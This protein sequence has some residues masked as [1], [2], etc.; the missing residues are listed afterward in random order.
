MPAFDRDSAS[1]RII[2]S[3]GATPNP[4]R[5]LMLLYMACGSVG[6]LVAFV[7]MV[8]KIALLEDPSYVPSCSINPILSCGSIMRTPQSE[9]LGFPNPL[10]GIAG[11]AV[12]VTVG[13]A[14]WADASFRPW[15]WLGLQIATTSAVVFVHWLIVQSLYRI[16]ALCLYCVVVWIV[17]IAIFWYTTLRNVAA[18][19]P[20]V[21]Q[22]RASGILDWVDEYHAVVLTIWYVAI[23]LLVAERFWDYWSTLLR[24]S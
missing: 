2:A 12:I 13:T 19:R 21:E 9:A 17:T 15:F 6:F 1:T 14:L 23:A 11:F 18:V 22:G 16:D 20:R 7:L 8:E 10:L 3:A 4:S 24:T 5:R